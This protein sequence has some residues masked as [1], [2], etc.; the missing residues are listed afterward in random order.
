MRFVRLMLALAFLCFSGDARTILR[1]AEAPQSFPLSPGTYWIYRGLVRSW[2]EGSS[3]GKVSDVTWKMSVTRVVAR[4]GLIAAVVRGF[5]SDLDWSDGHADALLSILLE[6]PDGK[7]YLVSTVDDPSILEQID[8]ANYPL[9][10]LVQ[11]ADDLLLEL[12]L[13]AGERFGCDEGA[14]KRA[15]GEYCW[16]V[17]TPH[18]TVLAGVKGIAAGNRISY[19]LDFVTNP[20]DTE[21]EFVPGVGIISYS[22]HHHGT[23]AETELHL[24]EFHPAD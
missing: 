8:N 19:Q 17:G 20:D 3:I 13:S 24:I 18:P 7:F 23:I 21:I 11:Q 22:Y 1:S 16:V 14:A 6:T 12:P 15:D 5:P 2:V 10:E 4:D 9:R